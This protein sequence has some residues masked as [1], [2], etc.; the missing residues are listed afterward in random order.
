[1][2]M[3]TL[4]RSH[5]GS[6]LPSKRSAAFPRAVL[7]VLLASFSV[8]GMSV[9]TAQSRPDLQRNSE[10]VKQAVAELTRPVAESVVEIRM[11]ERTVA[12]GTVVA[13]NGLVVTKAS[14][15]NGDGPLSCWLWDQ[16]QLAPQIVA[17]DE[18]LDLALLRIPAESLSPVDLS[19][20]RMPTAGNILVAVGSAGQPI[21][22]GIAEVDP[23]KFDLRQPKPNDQA[24]LGVNCSVDPS[25]GG[26][27]IEQVTPDSAARRA[28][29][30]RGDVI[31]SIDD[32][33]LNLVDQLVGE[34]RQH[35]VGEQVRLDV[36]RGDKQM[37][38]EATLGRRQLHEPYDQW[39]GGPYST[40][41]F[42][43]DSVIVH[44][45]TIGLHQCGGPLLDTDGNVVGVNIA[46]ALRVA[47]YALP[48]RVVRAF[49][50]AHRP[51]AEPTDSSV[52]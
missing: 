38:I 10:D 33:P 48:A 39:G 15:I 49:V 44:D 42:G 16:R 31:V 41:R 21:G 34:V 47:S 5:S 45:A 8:A 23:R 43:F 22:L 26:L 17:T 2:I 35:Q 11:G 46:R 40:R 52:K 25:I 14:E 29:L 24:Y 50:E 4:A 37:K 32:R 13:R 1:M 12:F 18:E 19:N 51:A 7:A 30:R 9:A 28:G 36:R 27:V 3:M 6:A 20:E